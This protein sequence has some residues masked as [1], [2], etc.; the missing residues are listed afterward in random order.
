MTGK[1]NIVGDWYNVTGGVE[2]VGSQI[3]VNMKIHAG[4]VNGSRLMWFSICTKCNAVFT[5]EEIP[6]QTCEEYLV[7][8]I[9]EE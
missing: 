9:H 1:H 2:V 3:K 8:Q 7:S 6:D 4:P 5:R